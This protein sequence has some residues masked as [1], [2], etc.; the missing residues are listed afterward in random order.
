[1]QDADSGL[2]P[3]RY[4]LRDLM[5]AKLDNTRS[6]PSRYPVVIRLVTL[7]DLPSANNE[8]DEADQS[9]GNSQKS[10]GSAKAK[11]REGSGDEMCDDLGD[12][13]KV[14]ELSG[15]R[16]P[17]DLG[18]ENESCRV[19]VAGLG[20]LGTR[21]SPRGRVDCQPSMSDDICRVS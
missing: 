11:V 20:D 5:Q 12:Q 9:D 19:Q 7:S 18:S 2:V 17:S 10:V 3:E 15:V 16:I 4:R 14:R 6:A 21:P 8:K 13:N 1:M